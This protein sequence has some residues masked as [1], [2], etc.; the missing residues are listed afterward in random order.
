MAPYS[1]HWHAGHDLAQSEVLLC[2]KKGQSLALS[3]QKVLHGPEHEVSASPLKKGVA[4]MHLVHLLVNTKAIYKK[5][6]KEKKNKKKEKKKACIYSQGR[7]SVCAIERPLKG[8]GLVCHNAPLA[9]GF[10]PSMILWLVARRPCLAYQCNWHGLD[11]FDGVLAAPQQICGMILWDLWVCKA[12]IFL[13]DLPL[14]LACHAI[15]TN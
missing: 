11:A 10:S 3:G 4:T 15:Y 14:W 13:T 12:P 1:L 8:K 5:R 6:E 2:M 7:K 9:G